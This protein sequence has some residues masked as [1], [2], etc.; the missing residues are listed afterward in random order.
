ML[1]IVE[2]DLGLDTDLESTVNYVCSTALVRS[3]AT[4]VGWCAPFDVVGC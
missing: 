3:G 1:E 4:L 2:E